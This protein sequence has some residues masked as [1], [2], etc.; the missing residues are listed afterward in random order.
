MRML[1]PRT[2]QSAIHKRSDTLW[3]EDIFPQK[4]AQPLYMFHGCVFRLQQP[5]FDFLPSFIAS[6]HHAKISQWRRRHRPIS[7]P[8]RASGQQTFTLFPT[9][10][11]SNKELRSFPFFR[12]VRSLHAIMLFINVQ[13]RRLVYTD[14]PL[15]GMM[16]WFSSRK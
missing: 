13:G 14:R 8:Y 15:K 4:S 10:V 7:E 6:A 12:G 5:T 11:K 9:K 3:R 16:L 1:E 2:S